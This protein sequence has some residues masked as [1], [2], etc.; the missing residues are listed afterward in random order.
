MSYLISAATSDHEPSALS[1]VFRLGLLSIE[2]SHCFITGGGGG[3][4]GVEGSLC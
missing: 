2:E 3:A 4:G 1:T